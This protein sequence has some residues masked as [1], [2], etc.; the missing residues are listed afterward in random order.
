MSRVYE[1][2]CELRQ[3]KEVLDIL[4]RDTISACAASYSKEDLKRWY[5]EVIGNIP[6]ILE[7]GTKEQ[8]LESLYTHC[9]SVRDRLASCNFTASVCRL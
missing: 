3:A 4:E 9:I 2:A 7:S 1:A 5:R 8:L 6:E